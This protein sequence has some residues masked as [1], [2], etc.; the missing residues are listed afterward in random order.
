MCGEVE[1][2][3]PAPGGNTRDAGP[4]RR[5]GILADPVSHPVRL[6]VIV[7]RLVERLDDRDNRSAITKP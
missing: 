7:R 5:P 3:G 1:K 6:G 4:L 2:K